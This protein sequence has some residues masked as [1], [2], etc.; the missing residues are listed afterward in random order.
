MTHLQFTNTRMLQNE[1]EIPGAF[2]DKNIAAD[3]G[4]NIWLSCLR[5][6]KHGRMNSHATALDIQITVEIMQLHIILGLHTYLHEL[7]TRMN[8]TLDTLYV[9]CYAL[10]VADNA[11]TG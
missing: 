8:I 3:I 10:A 5:R 11:K 2:L 1:T 9:S 7:K 4:E 6:A